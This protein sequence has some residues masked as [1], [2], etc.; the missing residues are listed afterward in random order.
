MSWVNGH[1]LILPAYLPV[2]H[3]LQVWTFSWRS[4]YCCYCWPTSPLRPRLLSRLLVCTDHFNRF[5]SSRR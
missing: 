3:N 2:V 4:S 5:V 1:V